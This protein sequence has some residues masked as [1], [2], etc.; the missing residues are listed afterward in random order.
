MKKVIIPII[1]VCA[2]FIVIGVVFYDK[3]PL[4]GAD[5]SGCKVYVYNTDGSV[6]ATLDEDETAAFVSYIEGAE[7]SGTPTY[8]D[9]VTVGKTKYLLVLSDGKKYEIAAVEYSD[10]DN[11]TIIHDFIVIDG[12][13]Y[14]TTESDYTRIVYYWQLYRYEYLLEN[15]YI[16]AEQYDEYVS[17]LLYELNSLS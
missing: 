10:D 16:T 17:D 3:M 9:S 13:K 6:Q 14:E 1:L 5:F 7:I 4:N 11:S 12:V 8:D 15:D 2:V